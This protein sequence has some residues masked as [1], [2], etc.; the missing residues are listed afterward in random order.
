MVPQ[1][2]EHCFQFYKLFFVDK[3]TPFYRF[4]LLLLFFQRGTILGQP[5]QVHDMGST[6]VDYG[7]WLEYLGGLGS[8][9]FW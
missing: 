5:E 9:E 6:Q 4:D 7:L 1:K 3:L 8:D 2:A